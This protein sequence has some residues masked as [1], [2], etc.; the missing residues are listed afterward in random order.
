MDSAPNGLS[1]ELGVVRKWFPSRAARRASSW[2]AW[3]QPRVLA[4]ARPREFRPRRRRVATGPRKARAPG[5]P[6]EPD[7]DAAASLRGVA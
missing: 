1:P 5:E 4:V 3:V 2:H 6:D 7:L